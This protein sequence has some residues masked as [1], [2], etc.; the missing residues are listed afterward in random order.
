M[1]QLP[2]IDVELESSPMFVK[3]T[4]EGSADATAS[5]ADEAGQPSPV[6]ILNSP[7]LDEACTTSESSLTGSEILSISKMVKSSSD[8]C[9][10]VIV[11]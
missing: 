9:L 11:M 3:K 4:L 6:S 7:F 5:E 10:Q 1:L 2:E 8:E